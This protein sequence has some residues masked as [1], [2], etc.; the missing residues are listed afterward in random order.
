MNA[1]YENESFAKRINTTA[2]LPEVNVGDKLISLICALVAF[3][4]RASVVR[5]T[6]AAFCTALFFAFFGIIGAM[7]NGS[8]GM[9]FGVMLCVII[10][11]FEYLALRSTFAKRNAR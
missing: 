5:V 8:I 4:T 3:F 7:D 11:L 9:F 1:Y 6:K 2:T 10:T